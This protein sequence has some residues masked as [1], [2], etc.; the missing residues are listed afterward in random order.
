MSIISLIIYLAI[1]AIFIVFVKEFFSYIGVPIPRIAWVAAGCIAA[2][3]LLLW[4]AGLIGHAP[5]L[6]LS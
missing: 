6:S 5:T 4:L 3:L 2:I 1:I